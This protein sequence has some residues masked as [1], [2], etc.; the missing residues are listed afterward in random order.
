LDPIYVAKPLC[1]VNVACVATFVINAPPAS[2]NG[3]T[4][5]NST[6]GG[7]GTISTGGP[8]VAS[9]DMTNE[10]LAMY[11]VKKCSNAV[12]AVVSFGALVIVASITTL[13]SSML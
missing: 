5:G 13:F 9:V 11:D 12:R 6:T 1:G 3:T 10:L 2:G 8:R 7:N 4:G